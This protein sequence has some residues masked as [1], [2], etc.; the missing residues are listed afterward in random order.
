MLTS[1]CI[2][3]FATVEQVEL[4]FNAGL[5]SITGETGA[6]KSVLLDGL[7]L[8]LGSRGNKELLR[9]TSQAA[10]ITAT[11]EFDSGL[12][13]GSSTL[14]K[15]LSEWLDEREL[16]EGTGE[17]LF[18][19]RS[20]KPDGRSKAFVNNTP[21]TLADLK[22]L[23]EQLVDLHSQHEYQ[24]LL[25]RSTQHQLLDNFADNQK[26]SDKVK[27]LSSEWRA[28][29]YQIDQLLNIGSE[30]EA[31]CQLLNYQVQE[32]DKL[33]LQEDEI[34][35]L[36]LEQKTLAAADS[37]LADLHQALSLLGNPESDSQDSS[38]DNCARAAKLLATTSEI[39]P[40]LRNGSELLESASIQL[41]EAAAEI[42]Q[43]INQVVIDPHRLSEVEARL[44][45]LYTVARKHHCKPE[46]LVA[47]QQ[48]LQQ[49]LDAIQG[50]DEQLEQ[51]ESER[52]QIARHFA[53]ATSKLSKKRKSAAKTLTKIVSCK[54]AEL[55]MA[56]CEFKVSFTSTSDEVSPNGNEYAEFLISTIPD[57]P[58]APLARIA[59]G[60]ELS[61][62]SLAIQVVTAQTTNTPLL[63][64][65]E[66]D[67]GIGGAT[68]E[69]VGNLLRELGEHCQVLCVTH[70]AQVA[71]RGHQ[72]LLVSKQLSKTSATTDFKVLDRETRTRELARMMGG[73]EL[74][75]STLAHAAEILESA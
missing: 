56:H 42:E 43:Q 2:K 31:K 4:D 26:L 35:A 27:T 61:R 57:K 17:I 37:L 58:P 3:N 67:V 48:S 59:S 6:G 54:L 13:R 33:A 11:F 19:R 52:E 16:L 63:V 62:I 73:K 53:D 30:Q 38:I 72:Q 51:L 75:E 41:R 32:L 40:G 47:L 22:F 12:Q 29:N 39:L 7:A 36:E 34:P 8:T 28:I 71:A 55:N 9:D 23:G 45:A 60:G 44:D 21:I 25:K 70:Q 18:L 1:L 5:T 69:V 68:A 49:E 66:V 74:T 24:S 15:S 14:S 50:G 64:F 65:D 20:L 10:E 46:E